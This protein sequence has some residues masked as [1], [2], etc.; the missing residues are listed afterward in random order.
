MQRSPPILALVMAGAMTA[1]LSAAAQTAAA[2]APATAAP[3]APKDYKPGLADLML[4]YIQPRHAKLGLAGAEGNWPQAMFAVTELTHAL[5]RAGGQVPK[6]RQLLIP[7][8]TSA[9]LDAPIGEV[10]K[11]IKAKDAVAFQRGYQQLTAGCN[12]CHTAATLDHIQIKAPSQSS[13]P[14]QE[15]APAKR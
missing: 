2:P 10:V 1:P 6:W 12:A 4:T 9:M 13:F 8:M 3:A 5:Q 7:D 11:A 14:N 15:F